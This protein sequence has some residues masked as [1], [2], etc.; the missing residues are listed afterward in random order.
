[1]KQVRLPGGSSRSLSNWEIRY[2]LG[3]LL[4]IPTICGA[5]PKPATLPLTAGDHPELETS[6]LLNED[7]QKMHQSLIGAPQ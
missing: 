1:M 3:R 4:R 6:E 5:W 7:N 2:P